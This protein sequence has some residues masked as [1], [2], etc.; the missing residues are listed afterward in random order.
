MPSRVHDVRMNGLPKSGP[1]PRRSATSF[2]C[3]F[4]IRESMSNT[5]F[6]ERPSQIW[7]PVTLGRSSLQIRVA[8]IELALTNKHEQPTHLGFHLL[9][10][11]IL[12]VNAHL[13]L[14]EQVSGTIILSDPASREY[15]KVFGK[16]F[17]RLLNPLLQVHHHGLSVARGALAHLVQT[18]SACAWSSEIYYYQGRCVRT[19]LSNHV[20]HIK[21]TNLCRHDFAR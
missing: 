1:K 4:F 20:L 15:D 12:F 7:D 16:Q 2:C 14:G 19:Q 8:V 5:C 10:C 9:H 18:L 6:I 13:R 11:F 21:H 17:L 3:L